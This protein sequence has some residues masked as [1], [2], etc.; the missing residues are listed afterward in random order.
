MNTR[1]GSCLSETT[2]SI[3]SRS[4]NIPT[5]RWFCKTATAPMLSSVIMRTACITVV[6]GLTVTSGVRAIL[7]RP[8]NSS[9]LLLT[10][11][12]DV[13]STR[14]RS[15]LTYPKQYLVWFQIAP[16]LAQSGCELH[17]DLD[18]ILI[19]EG[20]Y[21]MGSDNR[22]SWESPRHRVW[23]D[24]FEIARTAITRREYAL[25]VTETLQIEPTGW[26]EPSFV[27]PE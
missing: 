1:S 12:I 2:R 5:R 20:Q 25:F 3:R 8:I 18:M 27:D 4:L 22:Y 6:F 24:G 16:I 11:R 17:Y 23:I 26:H 9:G 19:P 15:S 10:F 14:Q 21:W 13:G 7:N